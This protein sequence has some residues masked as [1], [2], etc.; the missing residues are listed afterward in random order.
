MK[1][2]YHVFDHILFQKMKYDMSSMLVIFTMGIVKYVIKYDFKCQYVV[3]PGIFIFVILKIFVIVNIIKDLFTL[4]LH[5]HKYVMSGIDYCCTITEQD[6]GYLHL[7]KIKYSILHS[8]PSGRGLLLLITS[9]TK[10]RQPT[11]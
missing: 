3:I 7:L 5:H 9:N 2:N 11:V 4:K 10:A 6:L 8:F 1:E